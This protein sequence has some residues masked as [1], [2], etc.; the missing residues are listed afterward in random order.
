MAIIKNEVR[1]MR[2]KDVPI[3][4]HRLVVA[5]QKL[6]SIKEK[7]HISLDDATIDMLKV[8]AANIPALNQ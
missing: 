1:Q 4:L 8:G 3:E 2:I 6:L 5:H 7:K